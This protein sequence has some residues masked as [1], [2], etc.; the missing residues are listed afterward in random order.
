MYPSYYL[1]FET[2][3]RK[4]SN[5]S[6]DFFSSMIILWKG[7]KKKSVLPLNPIV[8][9]F[10]CSYNFDQLLCVL[11]YSE[12][13]SSLMLSGLGSLEVIT[14]TVDFPQDQAEATL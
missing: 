13:L 4:M 14:Y 6:Q 12:S 8:I 10:Y 1:G 5:K 7:G 3:S 9:Y 11:I 2:L